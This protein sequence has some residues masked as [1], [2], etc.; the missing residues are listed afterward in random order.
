MCENF[1]RSC[2]V[3]CSGPCGA[4]YDRNRNHGGCAFAADWSVIQVTASS[5]KKSVRY[6]LENSV[7]GWPLH[8]VDGCLVLGSS[9][10]CLQA[11]RRNNR[12]RVRSGGSQHRFPDATFRSVL[13]HSPRPSG[14]RRVCVRPEADPAI[15]AAWDS[16][17]PTC[18]GSPGIQNAAGHVRLTTPLA[19]ESKRNWRHRPEYTAFPISPEH[20]FPASTGARCPCNRDH[21]SPCHRRE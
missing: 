10:D 1:A 6:G 12:S 16:L 11:C 3:A 18:L 14:D 5:V 21:H 13:W 19:K 9:C 2:S 7:S 20:Q 17:W 15:P 8:G 4:L